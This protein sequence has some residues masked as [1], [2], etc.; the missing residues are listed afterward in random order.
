MPRV[1]LLHFTAL[2]L[3]AVHH[4]DHVAR[5]THVG[6]PVTSE[7]NTFT[8]TLLIYPIIG[9]GFVVRSRAYWLAAATGGLA[10]LTGVHFGPVAAERTSDIVAGYSEPLLGYAALAVL[11][12]LVAILLAIVIAYARGSR[13]LLEGRPVV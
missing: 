4:I 7:L 13:S 2:A 11:I 3:S 10:L 12:A 5:G 6:W 8:Y 1:Y 9:L